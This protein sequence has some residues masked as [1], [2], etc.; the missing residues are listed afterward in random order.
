ME[1][2]LFCVVRITRGNYTGSHYQNNI[3]NANLMND[4]AYKFVK[5]IIRM[6]LMM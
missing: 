4:T 5:K 2:F 3:S 1:N 6:N